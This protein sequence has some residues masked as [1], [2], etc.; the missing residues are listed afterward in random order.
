MFN[1]L[2]ISGLIKKFGNSGAFLFHTNFRISFSI[3]A[4]KIA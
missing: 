3:S 4:K 2:K 1:E